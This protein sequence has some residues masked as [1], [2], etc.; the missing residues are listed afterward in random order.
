MSGGARDQERPATKKLEWDWTIEHQDRAKEAKADR[1]VHH[2]QPFLVDRRV[3][4]DVVKGKFQVDVAR[5]VFLSS[6]ASYDPR[7]SL[8]IFM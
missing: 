5:I 3:L 8:L 4:R 6:G 7:N 2:A 1:A